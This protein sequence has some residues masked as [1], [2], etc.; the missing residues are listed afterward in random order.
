M[1]EHNDLKIQ[2]EAATVRADDLEAENKTLIDRWMLQK[3]QEAEH[4]N[5]VQASFSF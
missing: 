2:L 4:L 5:E 1:T 3:M